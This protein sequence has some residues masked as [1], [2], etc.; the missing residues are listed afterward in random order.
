MIVDVP[1]EVSRHAHYVGERGIQ[2]VHHRR[3]E[4]RYVGEVPL[5]GVEETEQSLD[6]DGSVPR[7]VLFAGQALSPAAEDEDDLPL[8]KQRDE[9]LHQHVGLHSQEELAV[10]VVLKAKASEAATVRVPEQ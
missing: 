1:P 2:V 3:N 5:Q 7:A 6:D 9:Y 10:L 8:V 4:A